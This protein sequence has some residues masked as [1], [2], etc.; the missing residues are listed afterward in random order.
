MKNLNWLGFLATLCSISACG[1]GGSTGDNTT[2]TRNTAPIITS[3]SSISVV[4]LSV[5]NIYTAT[6]SDSD[7]DTLSYAISGADSA[8][9]SL[10]STTGALSFLEAPDFEQPVD[11]NSDNTYEISISVN[12]GNSGS[13]S[14]DLSISVTN[15]IEP[16]I[17]VTF[18]KDG[19]KIGDRNDE[20]TIKGKAENDDGSVISDLSELNLQVD[21]IDVSFSETD[22]TRW[23][24]NAPLTA[25][26]NTSV[27]DI[28]SAHGTQTLAID[29]KPM[30]VTP[31]KIEWLESTGELLV[32]DAAE[33]RM[34]KVNVTDG[35]YNTFADIEND[36]SITDQLR[37]FTFDE[38]QNTLYLAT[39]NSAEG[40]HFAVDLNSNEVNEQT[41]QGD[42]RFSFIRDI[43]LSDETGK[44]FSVDSARDELN[45]ISTN[46]W[47]SEIIVSDDIGGELNLTNPDAIAFGRTPNELFIMDQ[48]G[49]VVSV[50]LINQS[51]TLIAS[52]DDPVDDELSILGPTEGVF[53]TN[54]NLL[55]VV[56]SA[57]DKIIAVDPDTSERTLVSGADKGDGL[58]FETPVD[59]VLE[60]DSIIVSDIGT[61]EISRANL[62]TGNRTTILNQSQTPNLRLPSVMVIT[63]AAIENTF[64]VIYRNHEVA[65]IDLNDNTIQIVSSNTDHEGP[66][67]G[68]PNKAV[69]VESKNNLYFIN[70]GNILA[71]D[72]NTGV[73]SYHTNLSDNS[74]SRG[75]L[76][77]DEIRNKLYVKDYWSQNLYSVDIDTGSLSLVINFGSEFLQEERYNFESLVLDSDSNLILLLECY[78]E[79]F[80]SGQ[81]YNLIK[82]N[83]DTG[84]STTLTGCCYED[85]RYSY[86]ATL[87]SDGNSILYTDPITHTLF[88][89][90]LETFNTRVVSGGT[91]QDGILGNGIRLKYPDTITHQDI[92]DR[93]VTV[94]DSTLNG[95]VDIDLESGDRVLSIY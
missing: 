31:R 89:L 80:G 50:D 48:S 14:I 57:L 88:E 66:A 55:Y 74:I 83:P 6:A 73:K 49:Y 35:S 71:I 25:S 7:G 91:I 15:L 1:G 67:F 10:N 44:I 60:N 46:D 11:N 81:Y 2:E 4:E 90:D 43:A 72:V 70:D 61:A 32:L 54:E 27:F 5:D 38:A 63:E 20:I 93:V 33:S 41:I 23:T 59:A 82:V 78:L 92:E 77:F 16:V 17:T 56:D 24:I 26:S 13:D 30:I 22:L 94:F 64:Y 75:H 40:K 95:F 62:E 47:S 45:I 86:S 65:L 39:A 76:V 69:F 68:I 3:D 18:P 19:A 79:R 28:T 36:F 42:T 29:Q 12:D 34:L 87:S 53:N 52:E 37:T 9:F 51:K 85:L 8:L 21:G 84:V 58:D